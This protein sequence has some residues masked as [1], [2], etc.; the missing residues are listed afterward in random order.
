MAEYVLG[1]QSSEYYN[2]QVVKYGYMRGN[3][4]VNYVNKIHNRWS[5]YRGK[6]RG[7]NIPGLI[8]TAPIADTPQKATKRHRFKL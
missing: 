1:L 4:T 7:N 6:A 2:D 5:Q 3:E 8:G